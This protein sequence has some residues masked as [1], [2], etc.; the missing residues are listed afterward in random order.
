M[1]SVLQAYAALPLHAELEFATSYRCKATC[2]S[3]LPCLRTAVRVLRTD[4]ATIVHVH[5]SHGGSYLREGGLLV[6]ARLTGHPTVATLHGSSFSGFAVGRRRLVSFV[7]HR[8]S[9]VAV[10]GQAHRDLLAELF[11]AVRAVILPNP[12]AGSA[13]QSRPGTAPVL[14]FG[15]ELGRRKGV[16]V[17][18]EAFRTVRRHVPD[19]EL[20]LAGPPGDLEPVARPGVSWLGLLDRAAM[21]RELRACCAAVLPSRHEVQ[22]MF[23]L[24]AMAAGRPVVATDVGEVRELVGAGGT[25][26]PAEDATALA[27]ALVHYLTDADEAERVG[28][29]AHA[30]V[31]QRQGPQAVADQLDALYEMVSAA[32]GR[33]VSP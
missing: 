9:A 29:L 4:R 17:L 21:D 22:P 23:L 30:L 28:R 32:P 6:L 33:G 8:A 31:T 7:L 25:V 10:L 13:V 24:E 5:L 15:G 14:V 20:R 1:S 16:D 18:L 3:V 12:S 11:P 27:D 2:W 26:V 19:A